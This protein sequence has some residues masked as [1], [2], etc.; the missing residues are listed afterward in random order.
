VDFIGIVP[1]LDK[2]LATARAQRISARCTG[3]EEALIHDSGSGL[4]LH[5][6]W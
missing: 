5:V 1:L 4:H 6:A 3:P 2:A